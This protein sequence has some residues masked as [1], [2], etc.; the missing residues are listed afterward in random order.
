MFITQIRYEHSIWCSK[1]IQI[2][3]G[4]LLYGFLYVVQCDGSG[5]V[6]VVEGD[7]HFIIV[8]IDGIYK[9]I[10]QHFAVGLLADIQLAEFVKP[11]GDELRADSG[12]ALCRN[13][14]RRVPMIFIHIASYPYAMSISCF[15]YN[16]N[17]VL[18]Y[19]K[20]FYVYKTK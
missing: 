13:S 17:L 6:F 7:D 9:G 14:R 8:Q 10:D 4:I 18:A 20:N 11:E 15:A 1:A 16:V 12:L 19:Y 5:A 3:T 2:R